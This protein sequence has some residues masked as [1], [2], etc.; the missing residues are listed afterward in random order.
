MARPPHPPDIEADITF[1]GTEEGGKANATRS[2]Y[3]PSHDFGLNGML[4]DAHHE[5]VS[6]ESV[7]PGQTA[8]AQL[9]LLTPE[10]QAGRLFPG[11]SFTVYEGTRLVARG[12][13]VNVLN[14]ALRAS[15]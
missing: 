11:F 10:Y 9:W 12:V 13:I 1:L 6:A 7:G 15:A 4:N 5:Y 3:R 8:R 2:G 14:P